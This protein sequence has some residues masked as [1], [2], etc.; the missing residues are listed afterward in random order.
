[1][2]FHSK[3]LYR[4]SCQKVPT[5]LTVGHNGPEAPT[6]HQTAFPKCVLG[7]LTFTGYK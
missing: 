3:I 7:K 6:G 5:N 1:M 4:A 2:D